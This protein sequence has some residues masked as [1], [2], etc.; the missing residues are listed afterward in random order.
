MV[1]SP[2]RAEKMLAVAPMRATLD[3][4][5]EA[6]DWRALANPSALA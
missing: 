3:E 2:V 1:F 5:Q 4:L 6:F